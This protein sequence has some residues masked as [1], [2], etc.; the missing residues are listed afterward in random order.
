MTTFKA[1]RCVE[2]RERSIKRGQRSNRVDENCDWKASLFAKFFDCYFFFSKFQTFKRSFLTHSR[3]SDRWQWAV[4]RRKRRRRVALDDAALTH[5][6]ARL[7]IAELFE[8]GQRRAARSHG[9]A[10]WLRDAGVADSRSA[11]DRAALSGSCSTRTDE[12]LDTNGVIGWTERPANMVTRS[13]LALCN[14]LARCRPIKLPAAA[15]SPDAAQSER[16]TRR[17]TI[18]TDADAAQ[19]SATARKAS[20]FQIVCIAPP[21]WPERQPRLTSSACQQRRFSAAGARST[22]PTCTDDRQGCRL[23]P[24]LFDLPY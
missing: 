22:Q 13:T 10:R 2:S 18:A 17:R 5:Q 9:A 14:D 20:S 21:D 19:S 15:S 3:Q 12:A 7:T 4:A 11:P 16:G 1:G 23:P 8:H 24:P 6:K